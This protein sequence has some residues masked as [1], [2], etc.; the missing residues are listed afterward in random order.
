MEL[1]KISKIK[2]ESTEEEKQAIE[3]S[4][5]K[6]LWQK[7]KNMFMISLYKVF[8]V[9]YSSFYFYYAPFTVL[10]ASLINIHYEKTAIA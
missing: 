6:S 8:K 9:L 10:L 7:A 5:E 2:T 3:K 1:L 4:N